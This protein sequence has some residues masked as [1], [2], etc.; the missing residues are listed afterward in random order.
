MLEEL[1]QLGEVV[2]VDSEPAAVAF[3]HRRGDRAVEL[4]SGNELPF[5]DASFDV[6]TMLDVIEHIEREQEMLAE[7][8]RVLAPSG[9]VLL[10]V[11]AYTWMWGRQDEISHH[12]R[13]YTRRRLLDSL[14]RAGFRT[15]RASYFNTLLLPPIAAIR[16]AR[17]L[18]PSKEEEL[19]SDFELNQPGRL[20]S[21]LARLF[22]WEARLL[23][24]LDLPFGV[25]VLAVAG[26]AP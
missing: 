26:K 4:A 22:G 13:R 17:R 3:C 9:L 19:H 1:R 21:A 16:I 5:P 7:V 14:S 6:V 11:P 8:R 15:W 25:S 2:G 23:R 24:R 12:V 18:L 20:N 10:T